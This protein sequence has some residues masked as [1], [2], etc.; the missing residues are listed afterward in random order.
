MSSEESILYDRR[1]A[2]MVQMIKILQ[3]L[4]CP[5]Y[6]RKYLFPIQK[7]LQLAGLWLL[8]EFSNWCQ[9]RA[10]GLCNPLDS[11]HHLKT[12]DVCQYREGVV[13][14]QPVKE[15][16]SCHVYIGLQ[17]DVQI[18]RALK[19]NVRVTVKLEEPTNMKRKKLKGTAVSPSEPRTEAGL[20]WGYTIRAAKSLSAVFADSPFEGGYDLT[21]G[22]SDKGDNI[23]KSLRQ[24]PKHFSHLLI[25]FGGLKGLESAHESDETLASVEETRDLFNHYLNTCPNQGSNTIRTEVSNLNLIIYCQF[26]SVL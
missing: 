17:K 10:S 6:L 2:A 20:Y 15:G 19:Q 14:K 4:E 23:D 8:S 5:Q 3:Y 21:I 25:V 9:Y 16:K 24:I 13:T 7:D 22:T 18:D 26:F 11:T 12:S 1:N